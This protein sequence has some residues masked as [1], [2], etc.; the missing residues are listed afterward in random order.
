MVLA[1]EDNLFDTRVNSVRKLLPVLKTK[2]TSDAGVGEEHAAELGGTEICVNPD[3][4]T[5][6]RRPP[7]ATRERKRRSIASGSIRMSLWSGGN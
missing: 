3:G 7:F 4:M 6:P 5:M 2:E 1:A